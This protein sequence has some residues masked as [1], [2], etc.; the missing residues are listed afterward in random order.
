MLCGIHQRFLL[1]FHPRALW[2]FLPGFIQI[3]SRNCYLN[4]SKY[5]PWTVFK[6]S[7]ENLSEITLGFLPKYLRDSLRKIFCKNSFGDYCRDPSKD[8]FQDSSRNSLI[9]FWNFSWGSSRDLSWIFTRD[10]SRE[11]FRRSP[12][13]IFLKIIPEICFRFF[14]KD[15]SKISPKILP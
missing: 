8:L 14:L 13:S 6:I 9:I 3:F 10:H 12:R 1:G 2:R 15:S 5:F 7:S 4:S 11:S